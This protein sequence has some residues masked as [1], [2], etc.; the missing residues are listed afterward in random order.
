[1]QKRCGS[2]ERKN[3]VRPKFPPPDYSG[4]PPITKPLER[5]RWLAEWQRERDM[6][7]AARERGKPPKHVSDWE[8]QQKAKQAY[9]LKAKSKGQMEME[10]KTE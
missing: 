9:F 4:L 2:G 10:M 6:E 5:A 7:T 8:A 3:Y 1:M